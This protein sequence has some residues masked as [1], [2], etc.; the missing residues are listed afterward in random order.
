[1]PLS[2][3]VEIDKG[4]YKETVNKPAYPGKIGTGPGTKG[5]G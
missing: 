2:L 3:P 4:E 5:T 1:M